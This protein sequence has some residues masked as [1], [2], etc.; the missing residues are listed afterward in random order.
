M[1]RRLGALAALAAT[2]LACNNY[3]F[4]PVG[5]CVVQPGSVQVA[6]SKVSSAD[7]LFVV[8]DSPSMD[9]KQAG[10][11]ASFQDFIH[12]MVNANVARTARGLEPL[13]FQI[14]VTT[15]SIFSATPAA[16]ACVGGNTCC[17]TPA[18]TNVAT[19]TRGTGAGCGAGQVCVTDQVLDPTYTWVAGMQARCCTT[20][21]C[22]PSPGCSPGDR[23]PIVETTYPNPMPGTCTPGLAT[24]GE[25][26][27]V[28]KFVS[29]PGNPKVLVFPKTLD[30]AS[31]NTATP[32][33]AIL[34]RVAEFQAN[35]KVGSC[36]SGEEQHLESGFQALHL[37]LTGG[38]PNLAGATFPR[39][40]AKLVVVFVGD[41][42]DCSSPESAPLSMASFLVGADSC[43]LDK[44]LP[45][46]DQ[47]EYP[48]S[49]YLNFITALRDAGK[50]ADVSAAFIVAA[51]R[52]ADNSYAPADAC[53]GPPT[54]PHDPPATCGGSVCAGAYA[55][56]LRFLTLADELQANGVSIAEG[57]VCD[58]YPPA[59]FGPELAAI[60]DLAQPPSTLQLP[61]LPAAR[62]V[63]NV[64]I[65]DGNGNTVKTCTEGSD[66]C[67]VDCAGQA[68]CLTTGTSRCIGIDATGGCQANPG[69]TYWAEY[70]GLVPANGCATATDCA[71]ALGGSAS[72][73]SCVIDAGMTVGT[74]ACGAK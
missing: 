64:R 66:W 38:Q 13:D 44:N 51:A 33:P 11:A 16:T 35:V 4:N 36:G 45:A 55:Y 62:A 61:S 57:T 69:D 26:Y 42:D 53:V 19:C 15:S 30:W 41:E 20:S 74:C 12:E 27:P 28:G 3:Q 1:S 31:W 2:L 58:A 24:A 65:T 52:C 60:A 14:A 67:F 5:N 23:C 48:L 17:A 49:R 50:V 73:W 21:A 47:R 43:V 34:A 54:C 72:S 7:I 8:D 6:L 68:A 29:A 32:D 37:A 9:P 71:A 70:L 46:A 40:S 10:L 22:T 63:T 18:C 25:P 39:A 56:G 59:S